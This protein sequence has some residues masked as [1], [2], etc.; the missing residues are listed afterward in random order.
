VLGQ[1]R[2]SF[3]ERGDRSRDA[4]DAGAPPTG[5]RQALDRSRQE[6]VG[7]RGPPEGSLVQTLASCRDALPNGCRRLADGGG[8]L[9]CARSRRRD[10]EVEAI[11]Q[12]ARQLLAIA[13]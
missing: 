4:R 7:L 2:L 13:S 6:R 5:E 3:R 11:E 8:E 9:D 12:R 1:D 10:D